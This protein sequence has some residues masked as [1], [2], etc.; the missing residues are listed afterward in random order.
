MIRK[1][2]DIKDGFSLTPEEIE[3]YSDEEIWNLPCDVS[4]LPMWTRAKFL[5]EQAKQKA[6]DILNNDED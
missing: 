2:E 6:A 5:A 1:L 4:K 3:H